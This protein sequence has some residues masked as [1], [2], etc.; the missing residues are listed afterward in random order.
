MSGESMESTV[1]VVIL[2]RDEE[3]CIARCLDSVVGRGFHDIVVADTGS[4][5]AT[6]RIVAEYRRLGVRPH[7]LSWQ[8]SFAQAR[9][10]AVRQVDT[11]WVVFLDAD[12]WLADGA[13]ERLLTELSTVD[14]SLGAVFAPKIVDEQT[15]Q[16]TKDVP[17]VFR[18]DGSI[19]YHGAVHEYPVVAGRADPTVRLV[20]L[21]V[22]VR[23]DG[24]RPDVLVAKRKA[25]RN[26][27]L[28]HR[29]R[30]EDPGNPR[31]LYFLLR[32]PLSVTDSAYLAGLCDEL[33][34]LA[35][36]G[37]R[38]GDWRSAADYHRW[39]LPLCCQGL[40]MFGD[41]DTVSRYCSIMDSI[42]GGASPDGHYFR[43]LH[44]IVLAEVTE[45]DLLETITLRQDESWVARSAIC[46]S[47]RH[48][49][50][51]IAAQLGLLRG[52]EDAEEY[53]SMCSPWSDLFFDESRLQHSWRYQAAVL[54]SSIISAAPC[55]TS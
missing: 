22:E 37:A 36:R 24:Y 55:S 48:L 1:G 8:D 13:A 15:A 6:P 38:T 43:S 47:G 51:L 17:R 21:D 5:D 34:V 54:K 7:G 9:N 39:A 10:A 18:A 35:A 25:E 45:D 52:A 3:R 28:L 12:E 16:V 31:W 20:P 19:V 44:R 14:D 49:D 2:A 41:W 29:A 33:G 30:A 53:R 27:E 32:N 50:A 26:F 23:H 11:E 42:D 4:V 40:G 46:R